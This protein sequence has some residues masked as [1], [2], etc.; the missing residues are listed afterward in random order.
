M[1]D[2]QPCAF[3]DRDGVINIDSGYVYKKEDFV[4]NE[5]IFELLEFLK[6]KGFLLIVVTNQSGIARGFYT[7]AQMEK[8]HNFMQ[9]TLR[10]KLGFCF[11]RIYFCE[12]TPAQNCACRKPKIGMIESALK[13]FNINL[14]ASLLIGDKI[15][16]MQCA[17][18]SHI[19]QKFF[20]TQEDCGDSKLQAI[21]N[22]HIIHALKEIPPLLTQG[23]LN[24]RSER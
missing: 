5:G 21:N 3:F 11:D 24:K 6:N 9:E 8:L 12:H 2:S 23:N 13:D 18:D 19:A 1:R 14:S 15:T 4:F 22:L 16:D 20:I 17:Q 10:K 7:R